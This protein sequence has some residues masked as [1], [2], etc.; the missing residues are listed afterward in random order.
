MSKLEQR[1]ETAAECYIERGVPV[2]QIESEADNLMRNG[3]TYS[4]DCHQA[5]AAIMSRLIRERAAT[6]NRGAIA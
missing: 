3:N 4:A 1:L 5:V 6:Q 2:S